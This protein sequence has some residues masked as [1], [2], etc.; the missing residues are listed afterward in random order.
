MINFVDSTFTI[1]TD[2]RNLVM[3]HTIN[4][5]AVVPE[6][7]EELLQNFFDLEIIDTCEISQIVGTVDIQPIIVNKG[8][9][10]NVV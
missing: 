10:V 3:P 9:D 5:M 4:L 7:G 2:D 8:E 6:S 1:H